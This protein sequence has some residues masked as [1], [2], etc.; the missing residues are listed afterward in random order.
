MSFDMGI[1]N[2]GG[3]NMGNAR[4]S[5]SGMPSSKTVVGPTG[6]VGNQ[7]P[8]GYKAGQLQQFSP[9]Q[10]Q[11]FKQL[12]SNLEPGSYLSRLAG[13]E[14]GIFD[15][16]EAPALRQFGAMQGNLASRFSGMGGQGSLSSRNSSGFQNASNQAAM[17]FAQ[18]LQGQRQSLQ[19]KAI[20]ELMGLGNQ[21]LGQRPYES[22]LVEK[23]QKKPSAW[24]SILGGLGAA[25]PGAIGGLI[26]G[27]PGAVAG[28]A[29]GSGAVSLG[30]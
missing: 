16:I 26:G 23:Q 28:A 14:E 1:F 30:R 19:Q 10:M 15:E 8:S 24:N 17:D 27:P 18:Q 5:S 29:L 21:L 11:L 12:F 25:I 4:S 7:I 22:F 6:K 13:G 9:E 3:F 20:L 2:P